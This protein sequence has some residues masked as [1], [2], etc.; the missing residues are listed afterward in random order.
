MLRTSSFI[1]NAFN[2]RLVLLTIKY[3]KTAGTL[4]VDNN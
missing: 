2:V 4:F 3:T 1:G